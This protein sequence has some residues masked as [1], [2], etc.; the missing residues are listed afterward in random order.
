MQLSKELGVQYKTAW[1]LLQR[2]REA[3]KSGQLRLSNVV[4]IDETFI[5]GK[6]KNKRLSKRSRE[7]PTRP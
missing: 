3:C 7:R 6:E 1:Y 5:G 4:E 2:V